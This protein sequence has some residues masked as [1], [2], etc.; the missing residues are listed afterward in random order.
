MN[1]SMIN[2]PNEMQILDIIPPPEL[3]L[4]LGVVNTLIDKMEK[5]F[6]A[7]TKLWI[8]KLRN[9]RDITHSRSGFNGN[10][11]KILLDKVDILRS[12]CNLGLLKYI[13]TLEKF[14][15]VV[16]SC[17]GYELLKGYEEKIKEF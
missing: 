15:N 3:H 1:E 7:D 16:N 12:F 2:K 6:Q 5:E 8:R 4:I 10:A 13:N 9:S 14:N 17:F 11:C